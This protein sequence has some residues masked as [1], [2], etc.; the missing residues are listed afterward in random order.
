MSDTE[1]VL[2]VLDE[3]KSELAIMKEEVAGELRVA[4]FPSIAAALL[5]H[6]I[7]HLSQAYPHL[8]VVLEEMEPADGLAALGSWQADVAIIDDL[9]PLRGGKKHGV[10]RIPLAED[11]LV[12]LLPHQHPLADKPSLHITDL[13]N[14]RWAADSTSSIYGEFVVNVCRRSGSEPRLNARCKSFEM[15]G[16]M[17][18]SGCA[19]SVVPGLRMIHGMPGVKVVKVRPE[20]RRKISV[21][22]R[23]GERNDPAVRVLVEQLLLSAAELVAV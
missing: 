6:T 18:A 2:G 23:R 11:V 12:V 20:V 4:A 22:Y 19:V 16:A 14:E 8:T 7:K 5:P 3:A 1:R 13:R 21:A 15:V 17:V 10:E 9:C